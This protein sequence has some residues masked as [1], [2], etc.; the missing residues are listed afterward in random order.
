MF[1]RFVQM[2]FRIVYHVLQE[3]MASDDVY[4]EGKSLLSIKL[5]LVKTLV[6]A[7]EKQLLLKS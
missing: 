2:E 5:W 7:N 6:S 1:Q 4:V 3:S